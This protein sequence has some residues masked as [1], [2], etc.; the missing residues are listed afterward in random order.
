MDSWSEPSSPRCLSPSLRLRHTKP[1]RPACPAAFNGR[2]EKRRPIPFHLFFSFP[3]FASN[4][5][6]S[7]FAQAA[8]LQGRP[9]L[10]K[11]AHHVAP[12]RFFRLRLQQRRC[13][14]VRL[15]V[16]GRVRELPRPASPLHQ[17]GRGSPREPLRAHQAVSALFPTP[18]RPPLS[19]VAQPPASTLDTL[20]CRAR[21]PAPSQRFLHQLWPVSKQNKYSRATSLTNLPNT[22]TFPPSAASSSSS[23]SWKMPSAS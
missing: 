6:F 12:W 20:R 17:Q 9:P 7:P 13:S 18:R 14:S 8:N 2:E 22:A 23:P 3:L 5:P 16:A 15:L 1:P 10:S 19:S 11:S 21:C 4:R